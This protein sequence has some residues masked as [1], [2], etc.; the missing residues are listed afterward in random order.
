M[1]RRAW[2]FSALLHAVLLAFAAFGLPHLFDTEPDAT[3]ESIVV[4]MVDLADVARAPSPKAAAPQEE[5]RAKPEEPKPEPPPPPKPPEPTPPPQPPPPPPPHEPAPEPTPA[6]EAKPAPQPPEPVKAPEPKPEPPKPKPKPE[7]PKPNLQSLLKNLAKQEPAP[8]S[9]ETAKKPDTKKPAVDKLLSDLA[10]DPA[11]SAQPAVQPNVL[12]GPL[13]NTIVGAIRKK[14]E[15]NWSV[16]AGVKDA[17]TM[18]VTLR[19]E[20]G[21]D[22]AVTAARIE[23]IERYQSDPAFRAMADSALRAVQIASPFEMLRQH[24][25]KYE[26]WRVI[27]MTFRPPV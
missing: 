5:K 20:L 21:P 18:S 26:Q 25:D 17:H 10:K 15:D 8:K 23:D 19:I 2:I 4:G 9:D 11:E 7:P 27:T 6:P 14:V 24:L 16:A 22:G 12:S 13:A 3:E 1:S